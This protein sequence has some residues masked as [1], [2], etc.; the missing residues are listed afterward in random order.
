MVALRRAGEPW[1]G[2][3]PRGGAGALPFAGSGLV[4]GRVGPLGR[5]QWGLG[6][7]AWCREVLAGGGG[8]SSPPSMD[9]PRRGV[10]PG[11][12][13]AAAVAAGGTG[14][15]VVGGVVLGG[16]GGPLGRERGGRAGTVLGRGGGGG[17]CW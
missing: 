2:A 9:L 1:A 16:L 11:K 15:V 5:G 4:M 3:A 6:S 7:P 13:D 14:P 10:A 12:V 8:V 17:L